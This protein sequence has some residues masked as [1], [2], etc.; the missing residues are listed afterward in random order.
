MRVMNDPVL[1]LRRNYT[2]AFLAYLSRRDETGLRA[3]Y[4]LGRGA[5]AHG[6]SLLDLVQVHHAVV[7]EVLVTVR[8]AQ[9]LD[10]IARAA[11]AFLVE[12]LA[13]FE[14]AQRG[15]MEKAGDPTSRQPP[16]FD[17]SPLPSPGRA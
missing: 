1:R 2:P 11:A 3:A 4:E 7:L 5:M 8:S 12:S 14:M 13:S 6:V 10:D 15:F 16:K 9:E 17:P